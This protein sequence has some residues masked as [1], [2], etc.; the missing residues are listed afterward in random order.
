LAAKK[1]LMVFNSAGNE[2][3]NSWHFLITPSDGDSVVAVG[4]VNSNGVIGGFSSYG[5]SADGRVKPDMASVGVA[6]VIQT[7]VNTIGA[8]NGT[9]FACPNM[10]GMATCLWQGFPEFNNMKIIRAL[11]EAG[12]RFSN[13]D[14]RTGYGIPDLKMAFSRLL[15][16][17]ATVSAAVNNPCEIRIS[18]NSKDVSAMR[19]EVERKAPGEMGYTKV[20]DVDATG[21]AIL[22]S[23]GY[24]FINTLAGTPSGIFTYRIR[25]IIDTTQATFAS[26]YIDSA[27]VTV[28]D[29]CTS[30][31]VTATRIYLQPN[32]VTS[33]IAV[34]VVETTIDIPD[35]TIAVFNAKGQLIRQWKD[36][37]T[38]GKKV[39][40]FPAGRL[41]KGA[42][43]IR[44]MN[45]SAVLGAVEMIR[46]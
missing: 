39:L 38:S 35:M 23:R 29:P 26:V 14:D 5:P 4:A 11:Q 1:G 16:E 19:Y 41:P 42:Y 34:L 32:P 21:G 36:A 40:E 6:A 2:G 17:Y 10:A 43:Y 18:W 27:Q 46:L 37:K 28:N 24:E 3:G 9:S 12:H 13:P 44:V 30:V 7:T 33:D 22:A 45:G 8:A 20:A 25:Q 15:A 31:P